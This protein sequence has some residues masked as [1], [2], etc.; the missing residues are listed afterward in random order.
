MYH[1]KLYSKNTFMSF[2]GKFSENP[3]K[4]Y[5][6]VLGLVLLLGA[7]D[8]S[9]NE[10]EPVAL[11]TQLAED[12]PA[13]PTT[14]RDPSTGRPIAN[15]LFTLYDLDT[16][17]IVLSSSVTDQAQRRSDSTGTVWDIGFQGTTVIFNGGTSG[18]G[19]ASAQILTEPY[20]EVVEAPPSGYIADGDNTECPSIETPAGPRPG[21]T[22]ALCT[23]SGNGWYNYISS[24]QGGIITP[25]PGRTIVLKT[26]T[27]N[28]ASLR[29]LS[30]Y[31]GNPSAPDA[32][33][34]S[35]YY[36]FEYIFQPDKDSRDLRNTT[37]SNEQTKR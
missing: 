19:Q 15:N 16:N 27:G 24:D 12:I 21:S 18:P 6:I 2:R 1:F 35:R 32:S 5:L 7:C 37:P 8:S 31:Q 14:G 3:R 13:D 9:D 28:Y 17:E 25:I 36:T 30:Y 29:F 22:L 23:G 10:P 33:H 34:A 4:F 26:A 11:D 20:D